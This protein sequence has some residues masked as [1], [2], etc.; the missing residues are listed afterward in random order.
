[1][2]IESGES[3]L[4]LNAHSDSSESCSSLKPNVSAA[5]CL[6]LCILQIKL[7][8]FSSKLQQ[9]LFFNALNRILKELGPWTG[10][11]FTKIFLLFS[12]L[13]PS[14]VVVEWLTRLLRT[15]EVP[16]SNL[17]RVTGYP[18]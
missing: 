2:Q 18:D 11:L 10:Y 17:G 14:N 8:C 9:F 5:F 16:G 3:F 1:V 7:L 12:S 4:R 13:P 15:L 6:L